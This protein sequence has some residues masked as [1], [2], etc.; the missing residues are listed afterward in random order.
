MH[1]TPIAIGD[2]LT[3]AETGKQFVAQRDGCTVNY[4]RTSTGDVLS[5][6][7]AVI[8]ERRELLDRSRPF[9]GYLSSDGK[10]FTTWKGAELGAVV[11]IN[12]R[13]GRTWGGDY[14]THIRVRDVHGGMWHGRGAGRGCCITLRPCK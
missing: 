3:C 14:L 10:T 4:A 1:P 2:T 11:R 12:E 6:E 5:D 13:A 9:T 8:R 7:G